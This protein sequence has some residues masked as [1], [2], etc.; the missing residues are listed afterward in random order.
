MQPNIKS[1][2][3]LNNAQGDADFSKV[4]SGFADKKLQVS[5]SY[6]GN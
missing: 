3:N 6:M 5:H 1:V 4:V 2:D